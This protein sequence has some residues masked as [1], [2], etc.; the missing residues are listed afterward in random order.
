[1]IKVDEVVAISCD[2]CKKNYD[3]PIE[4]QAFHHLEKTGSYGFIFGDGALIQC[5]ICQ[6]CIKKLLEN[7]LRVK[8]LEINM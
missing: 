7:F 5:D 2:V 3:D 6:H 4:I 1:M 8:H